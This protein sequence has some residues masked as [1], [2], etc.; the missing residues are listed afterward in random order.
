MWAHTT[1]EGYAAP[2]RFRWL[3]FRWPEHPCVSP[4][5][6][7]KRAKHEP[8]KDGICIFCDKKARQ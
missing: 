4:R 6:G 8:D 7:R 2:T 3:L 5:T 1:S